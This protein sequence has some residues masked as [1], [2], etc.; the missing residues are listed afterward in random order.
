MIKMK[1]MEKAPFSAVCRR[2]SPESF[3]TLYKMGVKNSCGLMRL[4]GVQNGG[5][6]FS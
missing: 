6:D 3:L 1:K 2:L 4:P 5:K